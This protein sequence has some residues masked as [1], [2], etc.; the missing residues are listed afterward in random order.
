MNRVRLTSQRLRTALAIGLGLAVLAPGLTGCDALKKLIPGLSSKASATPAPRASEDAATSI[1]DQHT[2]IQL[3]TVHVQAPAAL[4]NGTRVEGSRQDGT[5]SPEPA[6]TNA[7]TPRPFGL[8]QA[9]VSPELPVLNAFVGVRGYDLKAI[10]LLPNR[11]TDDDGMTYFKFVPARI[12]FFLEAEVVVKGKTVQ[13]LGLTRTPEEGLNSDVTIDLASTLVAREL[14]R[15]WQ[16]TDY[17]VSYADL[18]PKDFN[19]LLATVRALLRNGLPAD[20]PLDLT[21]VHMPAGKWDLDADKKDGAVAYL[22]QLALRQDAINKEVD[23]LY[24]AVN[25][26]LCNCR[27]DTRKLV[28]R[29]APF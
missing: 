27:D 13:L 28:A 8:L 10:Q 23:R 15:I 20:I 11:Y 17:R 24:Q 26:S 3:L 14:L 2:F 6:A 9:A 25:F 12:A 18:S 16:L 5:A 4:G 29:P 7:A 1:A 19:P 22:N 21:T